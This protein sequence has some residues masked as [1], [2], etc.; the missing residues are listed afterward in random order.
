MTPE[1]ERKHRRVWYKQNNLEFT[2]IQLEKLEDEIAALCQQLA[3]VTATRDMYS[4]QL[5]EIRA[6]FDSPPQYGSRMN[7]LKKVEEIANRNPLCDTPLSKECHELRLRVSDL[8]AELRTARLGHTDVAPTASD[9]P[10]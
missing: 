5:D 3:E 2:A 7:L 10:E 9:D 8:E 4:D 1:E 6:L